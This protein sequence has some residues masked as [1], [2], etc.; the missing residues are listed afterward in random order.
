MPTYYEWTVELIQDYRD[1]CN[2]IVDSNHFDTYT[3]AK[4][5]ADSLT[6]PYSHYID[7]GVERR[8]YDADGDLVNTAWAYIAD[9]VLPESFEDAYGRTVAKV[10][11]R[12][13]KE[14]QA[15]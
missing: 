13:H 10:P 5:Y 2:D 11:A 4:R 15:A 14:L 9:G 8:G 1:G 12:F 3:D 6:I 7:I